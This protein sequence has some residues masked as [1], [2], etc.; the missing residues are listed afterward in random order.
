MLIEWGRAKGKNPRHNKQRKD[1]EVRRESECYSN[2]EAKQEKH[3]TKTVANIY[4]LLIIA[5]I[6]SVEILNNYMIE[7]LLLYLF[8]LMRKLT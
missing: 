7:V 4:E 5:C 8:S 2:M 3:S 1:R 6:I